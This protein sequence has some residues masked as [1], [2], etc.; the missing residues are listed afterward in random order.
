MIPAAVM[1]LPGNLRKVG[2]TLFVICSVW[3][4][5]LSDTESKGI[6]GKIGNGFFNWYGIS[7]VFG[8]VLSYSRLFALGLAT[9]I[10]AQVVNTIAKMISGV[11]G[12]GPVLMIGVLIGGHLFNIVINALGGFIHT[13][14]LQFVEY[15]TKFFEGGGEPFRPFAKENRYVVVMDLE[16]LR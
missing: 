14:R 12:L 15:F 9:G 10:I 1:L 8:D 2:L 7:G 11:P 16:S 6:A 4:I 3:I 13:A 5:A